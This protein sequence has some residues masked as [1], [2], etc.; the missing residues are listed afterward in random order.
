VGREGRGRSW[1]APGLAA[2]LV[3]AGCL[4]APEAS[5]TDA[6]W[7]GDASS[8]ASGDSSGDG[9]Q[10]M[11][12]DAF[13]PPGLD[14][15]TWIDSSDETALVTVDEPGALLLSASP[16]ATSPDP[17]T[18]AKLWSAGVWSSED[19]VLMA[20]VRVSLTGSGDALMGW[21]AAGG[22]YVAVYV[23]G[24]EIMAARTQPFE[25]LG[26][27][28]YYSP[29]EHRYWRIRT[30][31]G[32]SEIQISGDKSDWLDVAVTPAPEG[33]LAILLLAECAAGAS[34]EA[35]VEWLT[36]FDCSE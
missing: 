28:R 2:P 1:L 23:E 34:I 20:E 7:S 33:P 12:H 3:L 19:T 14:Q 36:L 11:L 9:C 29:E 21:R 22:D 5:S 24:N 18:T 32:Q 35:R 27:R 26:T 13:D 10:V 25:R 17:Y 8:D 31:D 4:T 30:R 16:P 15:S 6:G